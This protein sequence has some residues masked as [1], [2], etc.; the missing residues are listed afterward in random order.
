LLNS[1][2]R[3]SSVVVKAADALTGSPSA[4]EPAAVE[5]VMTVPDARGESVK[6]AQNAAAMGQGR[7]FISAFDEEWRGCRPDE[8]QLV[9]LCHVIV[10]QTLFLQRGYVDRE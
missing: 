6:A 9:H 4:V 7:M 8:Q 5:N 10:F 2:V 3:V 1:I